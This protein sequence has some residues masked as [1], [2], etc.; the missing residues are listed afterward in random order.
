MKN[1]FILL[2][3]SVCIS[4]G[5]NLFVLPT[6]IINGGVFGISLI[7]K[8]IWGI[9]VGHIMLI[10]NTPIYLLSFSYSKKYF[11]NAILGLV[12]TSTAIDLL[13]PLNGLF[14]LPIITS[15]IL[16]GVI[17]GI[18]VGIMLRNHISPGGVD[19]LAL[20]FGKTLN[21]NPGIIFFY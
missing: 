5:L 3:S 10:I 17:I 6:H 21:V 12:F 2:F 11:T 19:L 4:L 1:F 8:Y 14:H 18:G 15:A 9:K 20:L 16:G 7:I 13:A